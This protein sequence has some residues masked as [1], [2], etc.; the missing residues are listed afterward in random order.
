MAIIRHACRLSCYASYT[1]F[2]KS[3]VPGERFLYL[4]SDTVTVFISLLNLDD[5]VIFLVSLAM[6]IGILWFLGKGYLS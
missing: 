4:G 1:L 2:R 3:M 6:L 5:I